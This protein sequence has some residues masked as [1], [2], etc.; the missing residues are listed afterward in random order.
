MA[1]ERYVL[2]SNDGP[3]EP[4]SVLSSEGP[5]DSG[6]IINDLN[7]SAVSITCRDVLFGAHLRFGQRIFCIGASILLCG[8]LTALF[9]CLLIGFSRILYS[10]STEKEKMSQGLRMI[11]EFRSTI[12]NNF[13]NLSKDEIIKK[14]YS[15]IIR[16][17]IEA[18]RKEQRSRS[19]FTKLCKINEKPTN[20]WCEFPLQVFD[21]YSCSIVNNNYGFD[22]GEPCLLFELKLQSNWTPKFNRSA[23]VLPLV[24]DAY[25]Q[26][27]F[28]K[29]ASVTYISAYGNNTRYGGFPTNKI[30][31]RSILDDQGRDVSDENGET[32]YD[33]PSLVFVKLRLGK[34]LYTNVRC[35]I[36]D[37]TSEASILNLATMPGNRVVNFDIF[38]P[39]I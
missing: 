10:L 21:T 3:D 15:Q 31:S 26:I 34:S 19:N 30:P 36:P 7:E 28:K 5:D 12:P 1:S 29:T 2:V 14:R 27:T 13:I 24:C 37:E 16:D 23:S 25:D 39:Y 18:Y 8:I 9:I 22:N 32:L 35:Y 17:Y 6:P 33:M 20:R 11:P 38:Y 4:V